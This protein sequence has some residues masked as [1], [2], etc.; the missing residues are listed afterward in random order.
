MTPDLPDI[1]RHLAET[2]DE[3]GCRID[4]R[5]RLLEAAGHPGP[6]ER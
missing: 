3:W 1:L 4:S 6:P 5:E 2:V